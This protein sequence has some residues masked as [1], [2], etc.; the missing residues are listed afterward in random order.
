MNENSKYIDMMKQAIAEYN[1]KTEERAE[2]VCQI[3]LERG[4]EEVLQHQLSFSI[5]RRLYINIDFIENS[6]EHFDYSFS[7]KPYPG[8][9]EFAPLTVS[10]HNNTVSNA[11]P[12]IVNILAKSFIECGANVYIL[13]TANEPVLVVE[14]VLE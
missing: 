4:L 14:V 7:Y 6:L 13:E 9:K 2:S 1:S 3:L 10:D 5:T 8:I 12:Y 11:N